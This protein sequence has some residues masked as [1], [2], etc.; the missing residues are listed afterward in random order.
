MVLD[1]GLIYSKLKFAL[2]FSFIH[3]KNAQFL[4]SYIWGAFLGS[5]DGDSLDKRGVDRI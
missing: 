3:L 4:L 1:Y 5:L 2:Q